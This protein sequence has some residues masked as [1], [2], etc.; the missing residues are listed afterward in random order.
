M[1]DS[2][3]LVSFP[4][5]TMG[6]SAF[7]SRQPLPKQELTHTRLEK[8]RALNWFRSMKNKNMAA[9]AAEFVLENYDGECFVVRGFQPVCQDHLVMS[10]V[11]VTCGLMKRHKGRYWDVACGTMEKP[12]MVY[13]VSETP[14]VDTDIPYDCFLKECKAM[15]S[16][17]SRNKL[18]WWQ[19]TTADTVLQ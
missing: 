6:R 18:S 11:E 16:S 19:V 10:Q 13:F 17:S 15:D 1:V 2:H 12:V 7:I 14:I 4:I 9:R 3:T 8:G 5:R